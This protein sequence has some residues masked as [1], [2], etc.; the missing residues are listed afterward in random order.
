[1]RTAMLIVTLMLVAMLMASAQ[2]T[3][4]PSDSNTFTGCLKG[5]KGQY[6][7]VEKDGTSQ[8]LMAKGKDLSPYVNHEVK[9]TGKADTSRVEGKGH[10]SG[11]ISV[12]SVSDQGP[13]KK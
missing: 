3:A 9:V 11:L 13:C 8:T 7:I 4:T 1:M 2:Q 5:S 6:Y 10:R 12:D